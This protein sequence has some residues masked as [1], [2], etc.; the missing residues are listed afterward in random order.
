MVSDGANGTDQRIGLLDETTTWLENNRG[1]DRITPVVAATSRPFNREPAAGVLRGTWLGHA[2]HPLLTDIPLGCWIAALLLDMTPGNN[3]KASRRL[4]AFGVAAVPLTAAAG[5][6]EW[7]TI[8]RA[9]DRRVAAVHALGN[10][11]A[12]LAFTKSWLSRR[13]DEQMRGIMWGWLGGVAALFTGYLGGHMSFARRVGTGER[14][15]PAFSPS[16][17]KVRFSRPRS[18]VR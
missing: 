10:T 13:R 14:G 15:R 8:D 17:I 6:S 2:L 11:L 4:I 5:L 18:A 16:G 1:I 7:D 9:E 12:A 3:R